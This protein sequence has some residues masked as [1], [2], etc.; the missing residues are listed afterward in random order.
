MTLSW[1]LPTRDD[2]LLGLARGYPFAAPG[3]SYLY[4]DGESLPLDSARSGLFD[5]RTPVLAHGSNRAPEQLRRKFDHLSGARS[6]IPVTRV[7]LRDYDVVYSAHVTQYGAIAANLQHLPGVRV[8]LYITWLSA[9]QLP[10]M[11][12]T[13]L[14][15]ENYAYGVMEEVRL[16]LDFGPAAR[17]SAA[18]VY[19]S[20]RGCLCGD[21]GRPGTTPIGL[22]AVP[23]EGRPHDSIGQSEALTLVRDRHRP[24]RGLE[25]HILETIRDPAGR[26][27]L[28]AEMRQTAVPA[29]APHFTPLEG[30]WGE[31]S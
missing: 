25:A 6:E 5:G 16:E 15:G 9:E 30:D 12:D 3:K 4:R 17:L 29:R 13:E 1:T 8:E 2:D 18:H 21:P 27:L 20:R 28:V 22:A 11:H 24:E 14:G 26:A 23:A 31:P 10:R 7:L 19:L